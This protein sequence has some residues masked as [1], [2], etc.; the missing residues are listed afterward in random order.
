MLVRRRRIP[1]TAMQGAARKSSTENSTEGEKV[2]AR[3]HTHTLEEANYHSKYNYATEVEGKHSFRQHH[4]SSARSPR[5][6][7]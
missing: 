2:L 3:T 7:L 4:L 5:R 6:R 1:P